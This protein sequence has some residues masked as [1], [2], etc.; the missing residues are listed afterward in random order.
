V[1]KEPL[2]LAVTLAVF[3]TPTT[4]A[5]AKIFDVT[6]VACS[7]PGF[8]TPDS[9]LCFQGGGTLTLT[10]GSVE[11][12][13]DGEVRISLKQIEGTTAL[14]VQPPYTLGLFFVPLLT[15]QGVTDMFSLVGTF[16]TDANGGFNGVVGLVSG[17]A[18][19]FFI[20]NSEGTDNDFLNFESGARQQFVSAIPPPTVR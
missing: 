12:D 11:V 2:I 20:V 15:T 14:A 19:G 16:T 10:K 13:E 5:A 1:R 7:T 4:V 17:P 9:P 18:L 6:L 8:L 3:G